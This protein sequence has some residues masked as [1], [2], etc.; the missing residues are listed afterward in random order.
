MDRVDIRKRIISNQKKVEVLME[1]IDMLKE[2]I[3]EDLTNEL[4]KSQTQDIILGEM[5]SLI[6]EN[7]TLPSEIKDKFNVLKTKLNFNND[8]DYLQNLL[9][10]KKRLIEE[11]ESVKKLNELLTENKQQETATEIPQEKKSNIVVN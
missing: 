6:V 1:L 11:L 10:E 2:S 7:S 8:S 3:K 4:S 5:L 9:E